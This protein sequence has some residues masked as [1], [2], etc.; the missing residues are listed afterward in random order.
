MQESLSIVEREEIHLNDEYKTELQA[1]DVSR[2]LQLPHEIQLCLPHL[3]SPA[4]V[5]AHRLL[6]TYTHENGDAELALA[7]EHS[8]D[9]DFALNSSTTSAI[10]YTPPV[11]LNAQQRFG[12]SYRF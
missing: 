1:E 11:S 12:K 4:E 3:R 9:K 7:D 5:D 8:Q 2:I 10:G 6:T